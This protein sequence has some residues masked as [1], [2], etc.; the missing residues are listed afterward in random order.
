MAYK[1][2][3]V[4][5]RKQYQDLKSELDAAVHEVLETGQFVLRQQIE[6]YEKSF[7][8]FTGAKHAVG[9]NS[10]TD[11]MLLSLHAAGIGHGDEVITVA[12][13][14][15]ATVA[16]IVHPGATP[17][18]VDIA[19]DFNMDP[20]LLESAITDKTKAIMPVHMEGRVCRMDEIMKI[21]NEHNLVVI[22]DAARAL[23]AKF[24][25]KGSGTFGLSGAFSHY[26]A[27]LLGTAG[28]AGMLTTNDEEF[29]QKI[30]FLR[31]HCDNKA[32]GEIVGYGF[33]SRL[34]NIHAAILNVKLKYVPKWIE[35]RKEIAE[36]FDGE[37][38]GLGDIVIPPKPDSRFSDVYQNYVIRTKRRNELAKFLKENE[39]ETLIQW[40][41]PMHKQKALNLSHFKLPKTEQISNEVI[42][43]PMHA[44]LSDDD[45]NYV[46]QM[47]KKFFSQN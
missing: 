9:L 30:R 6:D 19:D 45:V 11:A 23:G 15:V 1:V 33:N 3:M 16:S 18:L 25:G 31:N 2:A 32:T 36:I 27:K 39:I 17:I 7:A 21:A 14:Y 47:I 37:L 5:F 46:I 38:E 13:T 8:D 4:N 41:T 44:E 12:H 10:G 43:I 26:P 29:A 35:R 28:D 22:E 24:D 34:D 20:P 40:A 42:S